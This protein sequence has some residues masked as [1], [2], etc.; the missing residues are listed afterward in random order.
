MMVLNDAHARA[1][2]STLLGHLHRVL[3]QIEMVRNDVTAGA[4]EL[5]PEVSRRLQELQD[6]TDAAATA[7]FALAEKGNEP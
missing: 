5:S 4:Y 1:I 7:A 6:H 3:R 2:G